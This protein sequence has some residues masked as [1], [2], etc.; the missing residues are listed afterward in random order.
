MPNV[1]DYVEWRGDLSFKKSKFNYVD[2]AVFSQIIFIDLSKSVPERAEISLKDCAEKHFKKVDKTKPLGLIIPLKINDLF[3][4][5]ANSKRFGAVMLSNY[6]KDIDH[7]TETQFSALT[8][9]IKE[10]NTKIVIFSGT[11]DTIIGWKEDFNMI[12]K[13]PTDAQIQSVKYL[14]KV[15]SGFDG[16][17]IVL[18]H[19]KGGN[20]AIYSSANCKEAIRNNIVKIYNLDGPGIPDCNEAENLYSILQK[21]LITIVPQSSI[22]G[23]LFEQ[24]DDHL[25][26]HS[27]ADG[28]YQHDV[29]TWQV[30]GAEFLPD[31]EFMPDAVG[32]GNHLRNVL[33]ELSPE[34]RESF[35]EATFKL[36]FSTGAKTLTD[37]SKKIPNL[38]S[39]YFKLSKEEKKAI[40]GP[41]LKLIS[42]KYIR[43]C[44]L[45]SSKSFNKRNKEIKK[46]TDKKAEKK[47]LE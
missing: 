46:Q 1:L 38:F 24:N 45:E 23:R 13:T 43:K 10:I 9:F 30:K 12:F 25:I 11:D 3:T 34:K 39:Q 26:V 4:L 18:G 36:L 37:L 2:A 44:I 21:K 33:S 15:C 7:S 29:L 16:K 28:V 20:L 31:T 14:N 32:V 41:L 6:K 35:V 47:P 22:V 8:A 17:I 40:N 19:S 27:I 42:N 5:M